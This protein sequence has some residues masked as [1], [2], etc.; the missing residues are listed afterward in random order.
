MRIIVSNI[1]K[2]ADWIALAGCILLVAV[3]LG[4]AW[5]AR[6]SAFPLG[7][8]SVKHPAVSAVEL[9]ESP[10]ELAGLLQIGSPSNQAIDARI[11]T[12]MAWDAYFPLFYSFCFLTIL[13][14]ILASRP[15]R[16]ALALGA[17]AAGAI[18]II[19][20]IVF[21]YRENAHLLA[22]LDKVSSGA[23]I[24][25]EQLTRLIKPMSGDS[26]LKWA[27]LGVSLAALGLTEVLMRPRGIPYEP[28]T[29]LRILSAFAGAVFGVWAWFQHARGMVGLEINAFSLV[30]LTALVQSTVSIRRTARPGRGGAI[31]EAE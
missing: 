3:L 11:R 28:A 29:A 27:W 10:E 16:P 14:F 7:H 8:E 31:F 5:A 13:L 17:G 19:V 25:A 6:G 22:L 1:L 21:D 30:V 15:Q 4:M 20:T 26:L 23:A 24:Q 2:H 9:P 12:N 18:A